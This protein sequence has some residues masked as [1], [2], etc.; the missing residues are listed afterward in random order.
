MRIP[1]LALRAFMGAAPFLIQAR[2]AS[3]GNADGVVG[4]GRVEN[5]NSA[6]R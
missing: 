2:S 4:M 1:S 3:K 6:A 5:G